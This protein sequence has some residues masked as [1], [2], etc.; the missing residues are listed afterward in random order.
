MKETLS[1]P[2]AQECYGL[3]TPF[4]LA[5]EGGSVAVRDLGRGPPVL[6][7]HGISADHS[8]WHAVAADLSIDHRVV[9]PDLLGRGASVPDA[10]SGFSLDEEC[11][12]IR[13]LL[14]RLA[15]DAPLVA[16][17]SHGASLALA[18]TRQ[19][20][21][22]GLLL[23]S[24]V[25]PWTQRPRILDLLASRLVRRGAEPLLRTCRRPLTRYIL[26]RRVYG[27]R[28]PRLAE[29]VERYSRPYAEPARALALLRILRD[30]RPAETLGMRPPAG[31]PV[32]VLA[33]G[34]DRRIPAAEA[35]RWAACLDAPCTVVEG[36]G[37]G[38]TE[39]AP[40]RVAAAL[41]ELGR[42]VSASNQEREG[43]EHQE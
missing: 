29:A 2:R 6:L 37:H 31:V 26:T 24:P 27:K 10:G 36:A 16:G 25:T 12:R 3:W 9:L 1:L 19:T 8:E 13:A 33:G 20:R 41:R 35:R 23:V 15:I 5:V 42:E 30:W 18:L 11:G 38:L 28:P 14:A 22:S 43:D 17:H 40:E 21:V 32:A 4:L 7:L 39:E 34:A